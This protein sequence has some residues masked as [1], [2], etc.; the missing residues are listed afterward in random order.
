MEEAIST[1]QKT[2]TTIPVGAVEVSVDAGPDGVLG[3]DD[4]EIQVNPAGTAEQEEE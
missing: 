1:A 2:G 4:D 3:T